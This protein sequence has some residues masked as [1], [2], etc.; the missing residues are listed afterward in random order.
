MK[1]AE[2]QTMLE[3]ELAGRAARERYRELARQ[4]EEERQ[5]RVTEDGKGCR[6]S[7]QLVTL[8]L[9]KSIQ[10][11]EEAERLGRQLGQVIYCCYSELLALGLPQERALE[12]TKGLLGQ[13]ARTGVSCHILQPGPSGSGTML[14]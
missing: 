10:C 2:M 12:L 3:Q 11:R 1:E 5:L 4:V 9:V 7:G 13:L 8:D 6:S 14:Y